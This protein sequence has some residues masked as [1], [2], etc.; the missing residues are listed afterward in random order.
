MASLQ[1][2]HS[3]SCGAERA[4][5]SF[6]EATN[7]CT[8]PHGPLYYVVVREDG[9][10]DK[11]RVGRNRRQAERAL[12]RTCPRG[13]GS[14]YRASGRFRAVW[15]SAAD[16]FVSAVFSAWQLLTARP[17]WQLQRALHLAQG[18]QQGGR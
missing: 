10:A 13:L 7:G 9:R 14:G 16:A 11:I 3:R 6:R 17:H 2:K 12:R 5:T 8:C 15:E 18:P 4:W 1:A